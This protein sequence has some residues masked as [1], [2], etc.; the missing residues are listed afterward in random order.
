MTSINPALADALVELLAERLHRPKRGSE[1]DYVTYELLRCDML[2]NKADAVAN[3]LL[4]SAEGREI[5]QRSHALAHRVQAALDHE[6]AGQHAEATAG[7]AGCAGSA[8]AGD[9]CSSTSPA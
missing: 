5:I 9:G 2:R 4:P 7:I 6:R 1:T 8:V 3:A